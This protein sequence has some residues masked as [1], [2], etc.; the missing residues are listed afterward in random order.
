MSDQQPP[1]HPKRF[2]Y[3][4]TVSLGQMVTVITIVATG[5]FYYFTGQASTVD[6]IGSVS[7]DLSNRVAVSEGAITDR[8]GK[9]E[10]R[11][12]VIEQH[13]VQTDSNIADTRNTLNAFVVEVRGQLAKISDQLSEFRTILV[14]NH[15]AHR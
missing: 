6:R 14:N 1:C 4:G 9:L 15:A 10:T 8:V 5:L 3:S 12:A 7:N 11:A 2:V 13:Q